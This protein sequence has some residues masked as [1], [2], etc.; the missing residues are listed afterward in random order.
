[1]AVV[2]S[3]PL[4]LAL[5]LCAAIGL[6]ACGAGTTSEG[7]VSV[8]ASTNV[9]GSIAQTIGGD[10]VDVTSFISNPAADPHS[11]EADAQNQ[12]AVS[13]AKL[14]IENGGGY[15]D[16]MQRMLR[17]SNATAPVINAVQVSG[18]KP[19]ASGDLNEHVWYDL[20]VVQ[21][22]AG[23]IQQDL[24]RVDPAGKASYE[25]NLRTFVVGLHALEASL[26]TGGG[27]P[28][29]I[30]E[31]VPVYLLDA[32]HLS[33]VTPRAFSKAIEE[34]T[35]VPARL[36][37]QV[38]NQIRD[39]RI[40]ALVYNAQTTGPETTAVLTAAGAAHVPVVPVTE[41]VPVGQTYLAWMKAQIAAIQKAVG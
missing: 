41:T 37:Q 14:V 35:G 16:F 7:R 9:W 6:T 10:R 27:K 28:V 8:V 13:R 11:Y 2:V 15:D 34:G 29:G 21:S 32:M 20:T 1:M 23:A 33:V 31:P 17:A 12:L 22:V 25:A 40:V 26:G 19:D 39:H 4:A 5:V 24:V 3:R 38:E 30:T 18:K 36:L